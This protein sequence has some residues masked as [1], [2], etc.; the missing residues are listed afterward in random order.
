[1]LAGRG[2]ASCVQF[3]RTRALRALACVGAAALIAGCSTTGHSFD[4]TH[5]RQ[6]VPGTTTLAQAAQILNAPPENTY[7]YNDGSVMARWAHKATLVTDAVYFRRELWL[8]FGQDGTFQHVVDRVNVLG[9][10]GQAP[11]T[12]D[13][14][15]APDWVQGNLPRSVPAGF[16]YEK[17][18]WQGT[19][20]AYPV[21]N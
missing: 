2:L 11:Q 16:P 8:Q 18:A 19:V 3:A 1:M 20:V 12:L 13:T 14:A 15:A 21:H 9:D 4:S 17:D 10:T 7:R 6:I 5:L